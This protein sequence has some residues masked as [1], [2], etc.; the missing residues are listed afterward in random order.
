MATGWEPRPLADDEP[1]EFRP[2]LDVP[3]PGRQRRWTVFLRWLLLIPQ[4]IVVALLSIVAFFVTIAGWFAAL[5]LGRLPDPVATVLAGILAYQTRVD[6][7]ASL[8]VDR[9]PPFAFDAPDHPV[10]IE[11][12]RTPLNR[13]A[14]FFRLILMIPAA[15]VSS[16]AQSGWAAVSWVF[17]LIGIVLGRLPE[18]VFAATAAVVRYRMRFNAYLMML[19]PVYP[20]GIFGDEPAPAAGQARSATRPLL[21]ATSAKVLVWL[22][23]LLGLAGHVTNG[24]V[25]NADDDADYGAHPVVTNEA[26]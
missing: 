13:L 7:S 5:V 9:Y 26:P 20:K 25:T 21:L 19:T 18:P 3:A 22:F 24:A 4:F 16:L 15:I 12:R 23:L 2:A 11:L 8:L 10:Q 17:W 6:A 1:G 14:V